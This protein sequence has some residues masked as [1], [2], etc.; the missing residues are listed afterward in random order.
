MKTLSKSRF[1]SGMQC[2]KK[3]WFDFYR[4]DLKTPVD[5]A[6]QRIFDLGHKIG[7]LAW[8]KFPDGKDATP[9]DYSDFIPSIAN[10]KQW[11]SEGV[12]TIYE[13]TFSARN[14]FCMLDILHK[15][16]DEYWAIEVKNSTN[17]KDY[18][19]TDAAFQYFVMA[20]S[21]FIPDRFFLMHINNQYVKDGEITSDIFHLE[22]IT[23]KVLE[24]QPW[25]IENLDAILQALELEDEPQITIGRQ[26]GS[27]FTCDY[28]HHCWSHIPENSVFELSRIGKK[29][30]DLYE[31]NILSI[32][33]IPEDY[34]LSNFQQ[35][36]FRGSKFGEKHIDVVSIQN[37][38]DKWHFPLYFFDFETIFPAIPVLDGTRPYEQV[39]FQYSLHRLDDQGN[40]DHFEFLANPASFQDPNESPLKNLIYEM[41]NHFG[42]NGSI[43][44]YNMAFEKRILVSLKEKFPEEKKF[45]EDLI[46]RMVDLMVVFQKNWYYDPAMGKSYSIK[47]VL[48]ALIPELSYQDLEVSN[49]DMASNLFHAS[50][51]NGSF[52]TKN[53][54]N[55]LSEY[56]KLDTYA[57]VV[58]YHFLQNLS[59][60]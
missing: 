15:H 60:K 49:G 16:Q 41:K 26:C 27:P 33:D 30:W 55:N 25:V 51:E 45:L 19:L 7:E 37:F 4:K 1:V 31:Q 39:P 43:I 53:L 23:E 32:N 3:V 21:G 36:Q 13:A 57:M 14:V 58:L 2:H 6:Q 20:E 8:R 24:T 56:C 44:A 46:E 11:I 54:K 34:P 59:V 12:P 35:L 48:P 10:T 47:A 28:Q 38:V 5:E 22:D 9:E 29:S 42:S 50:V 40:L 18:H 17:V 52:V